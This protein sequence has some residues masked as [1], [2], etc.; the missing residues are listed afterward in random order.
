MLG[1]SPEIQTLVNSLAA[2]M[3]A[4]FPAVFIL[5]EPVPPGTLGNSLVVGLA[6]PADM[7]E[8][9]RHVQSLSPGYP[10]VFRDFALAANAHVSVAPVVP[11][12][13]PLTDDRSP[14]R[15]HCASHRVAF[16]VEQ[17]MAKGEASSQNVFGHTAPGG[18][19][20]A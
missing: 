13:A 15:P 3:Q 16:F 20:D 1:A 18:C 5:N 12:F 7:G 19:A 14:H 11:G 9:T 8:F 2:T 17:L 4:V 6:Q 10:Q